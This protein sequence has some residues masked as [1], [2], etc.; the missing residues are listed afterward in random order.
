[1]T[2]LDICKEI[3]YLANHRVEIGIL[4]IDKNKKGKE[5]KATILQYAIWNE[6]GTSDIPARPYA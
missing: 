6:F 5:N 4:A 3:D 2:I 1:M